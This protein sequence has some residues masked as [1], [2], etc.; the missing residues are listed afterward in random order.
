MTV[1]GDQPVINACRIIDMGFIHVVENTGDGQLL[2]LVSFQVL[3]VSTNDLGRQF[4]RL[5]SNSLHLFGFKS[6]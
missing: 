2:Y 3:K 4:R 1:L 5:D 6:L